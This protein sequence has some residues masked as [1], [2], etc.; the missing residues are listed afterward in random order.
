MN[1]APAAFRGCYSFCRLP[2]VV[3][4]KRMELPGDGLLG[5]KFFFAFRAVFDFHNGRLCSG[6]P[7][8][9]LPVYSR[10]RYQ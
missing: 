1:A 9:P 7:R 2:V 5:V 3:R 4:D 6:R 10:L 8:D